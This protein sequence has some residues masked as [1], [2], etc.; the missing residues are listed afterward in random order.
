MKKRPPKKPPIPRTDRETI[1]HAI[2]DLLS[3]RTLSALQISAEVRIPVKD[4]YGHLE[5]I[6]HSIHVSGALLQLTPAECRA[7]GF[8]FT[9]RD[10]LTPPSRCPVCR[11]EALLEPLFAIGWP[12]ERPPGGGEG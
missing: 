9:K 4:V 11:H 3:D 1:R 10:R 5:H 2:V 8:V 7:C 6:R 12:R